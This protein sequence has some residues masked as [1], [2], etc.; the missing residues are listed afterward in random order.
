MHKLQEKLNKYCKKLLNKAQKW[1]SVILL[2]LN[3]FPVQDFVFLLQVAEGLGAL[4]YR[5]EKPSELKQILPKAIESGNPSVIV[6][7][8][9]QDEV[10]PITSFVK[11]MKDFMR[12]LDY[13]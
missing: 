7:I 6:C 5:I 10:P 4:S 1:F 3:I 13:M 12:R 9:D 11:G 8:I 2:K